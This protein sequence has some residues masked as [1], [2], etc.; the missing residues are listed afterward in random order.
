MVER[1]ERTGSSGKKNI[2]T[3]LAVAAHPLM[4]TD[5]ATFLVVKQPV[6]FRRGK[7]GGG[8]KGREYLAIKRLTSVLA[9]FS[10]ALDFA[11]KFG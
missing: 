6:K 3:N 5:A 7:E 11:L 2:L 10:R 1:D 8:K 9:A 4:L